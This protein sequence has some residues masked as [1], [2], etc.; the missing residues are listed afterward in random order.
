MSSQV[1]GVLS[2]GEK[3]HKNEQRIK[4][5][6]EQAGAQHKAAN[7]A[8]RRA[9][10]RKSQ[11]YKCTGMFGHSRESVIQVEGGQAITN[12]CSGEQ[13]HSHATGWWV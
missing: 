11:A 3:T 4:T 6:D 8:G 5:P 2:W 12:S 13:G 7:R 9:Q 1:I 10:V